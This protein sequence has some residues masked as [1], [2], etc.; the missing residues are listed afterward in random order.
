MVLSFRASVFMWRNRLKIFV[1]AMEVLVELLNPERT[2]RST[3]TDILVNSKWLASERDKAKLTLSD[4]KRKLS[5]GTKEIS[6]EGLE[7]LFTLKRK[8]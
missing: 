3:T 2:Y 8:V 6:I 7:C 4:T 1:D 5:D